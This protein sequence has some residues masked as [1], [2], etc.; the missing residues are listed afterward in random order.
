MSSAWGNVF[1]TSP[2]RNVY[3]VNGIADLKILSVPTGNATVNVDYGAAVG[4]D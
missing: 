1:A 3:A 2:Q 4:D